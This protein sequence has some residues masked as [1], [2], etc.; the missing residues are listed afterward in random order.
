MKEFF[1]AVAGVLMGV[2]IVYVMMSLQMMGTLV[3]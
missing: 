2:L 3:W 1:Q